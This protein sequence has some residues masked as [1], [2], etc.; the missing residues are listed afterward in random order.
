MADKPQ[1][2]KCQGCFCTKIGKKM[3]IETTS[4]APPTPLTQEEKKFIEEVILLM[5]R[6][7]VLKRLKEDIQIACEIELATIP[8]YLYTYYSINR[9]SQSGE[10]LTDDAIFANKA[11]GHIMSVAVEEM[12]HM[13]L[14]SNLYYSLFGQAPKLYRNS[15]SKYPTP[16]PNHKPCGNKGPDGSKEVLIPLD[17]FSYEQLW[18][19]LQIE[20][21]GPEGLAPK[22]ENW[23]TIGQ[24]YSYIRCLIH[25][26]H[27]TDAD[28][29]NPEF[30]I[31]PYNYSPNNV[32]TV[33]PK[34]KFNSWS[35]P[36]KSDSAAK[37]ADFANSSD[38]HAGTAKDPATEKAELITIS[39]KLEALIAIDTICDQGE[40][41]NHSKFDD[42]SGH[43]LSHYY[44]F[45]SLQAQM[46]QYKDQNHD[47]V[48][49]TPPEP[50]APITPT[51]FEDKLIAD[52]LIYNY[53]Q[54]PK[55]ENFPAK[56]QPV[57]KFING[58]Y[59]YML[60]MTETI[61]MVEAGDPS[62]PKQTQKYYFNIALHRSMIWVMDKYIRNMNG[63]VLT[64]SDY[65]AEESKTYVGYNI[66]P[67]FEFVDLGEPAYSFENLCALGEQAKAAINNLG[68]DYSDL[69]YYIDA[70]LTETFDGESRHLPNV[71]D[72]FLR[73]M[74]S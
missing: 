73:T 51:M 37:N 35:S 32:D 33:S 18:H 25:S 49:N 5:D 1:R 36:D 34:Q 7:E 26:P 13:S 19:F 71:A 39:S 15:P 54:S 57:I 70:A 60:I 43:E 8:I 3:D 56:V 66:A 24:Y 50:P 72:Y 29:T 30:Q 42:P 63:I 6:D 11:G 21:P 22:V 44:K 38:S 46:G 31:Q 58:L 41:F 28:F 52:G 45:L 10:N 47:E 64:D 55:L 69:N 4:F 14:A 65:T 62:N 61:F 59:Q 23:V 53:P 74:N 20:N 68:S 9:T 17:K 12:L 48:L 40:G 16:L 2:R 67:T 27:I